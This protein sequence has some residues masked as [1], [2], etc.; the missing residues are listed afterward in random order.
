MNRPNGRHTDMCK[1]ITFPQATSACCKVTYDKLTHCGAVPGVRMVGAPAAN[2]GTGL[3][4]GLV[5]RVRGGPARVPI[6]ARP[7]MAAIVLVQLRASITDFT[8]TSLGTR[9]RL[10]RV[11]SCHTKFKYNSLQIWSITLIEELQLK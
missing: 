5:G 10:A 4:A 9:V 7:A 6:V 3:L 8:L 11:H 2:L 1:N